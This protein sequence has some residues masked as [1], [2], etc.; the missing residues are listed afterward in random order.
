MVDRL[1]DIDASVLTLPFLIDH[2]EETRRFFGS[3]YWAY[4]VDP[5]RP[6]LE[7]FAQCVVDQGLALRVVSTDELFPQIAR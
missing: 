5:H 4:G 3:D 7:V 2:V 1:Y 6:A